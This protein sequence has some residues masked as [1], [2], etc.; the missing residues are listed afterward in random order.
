MILMICILIQIKEGFS[1]ALDHKMPLSIDNKLLRKLPKPR[2]IFLCTHNI[3]RQR[4]CKCLIHV[5][6]FIIWLIN[7][8][9]QWYNSFQGKMILI[10]FTCAY[11][12]DLD[13][14]KEYIYFLLPCWASMVKPLNYMFKHYLCYC[15]T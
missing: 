15:R 2:D 5:T 10:E 12:L 4:L 6:Q 7:L 11:S 8:V 1:I 3:S 14:E 9:A 13:K